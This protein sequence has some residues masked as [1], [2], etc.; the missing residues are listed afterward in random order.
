MTQPHF[1]RAFGD[2]WK[3]LP[4]EI[5]ALHMVSDVSSFAGLARISRG[6]SLAAR[7]TAWMFGF[8]KAA[9]AC[10][11]I[12]TKTREADG[13]LWWAAVSIAVRARACAGTVSG[14]L[15]RVSVRGG[16]QSGGW[17]G[18]HAA[19]PWLVLWCAPAA[20][21]ASQKRDARVCL[22]RTVQL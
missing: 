12:V 16:S 2:S 17:G 1:E 11:V 5:R 19:A 10:P 22:G 13:E 8:P 7:L 15:W 21:G 4:S 3:E 6:S 9:E 20:L 14:A 18:V